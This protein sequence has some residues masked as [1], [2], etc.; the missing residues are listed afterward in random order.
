MAA[1]QSG[2]NK[3]WPLESAQ[4][5]LVPGSAPVQ[6][7]NGH[8]KFCRCPLPMVQSAICLSLL[9]L[10]LYPVV[11]SVSCLGSV[12]GAQEC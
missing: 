1:G 3:A 7:C 11:R 8:H 12:C 4:A 2:T 9:Q 5:L 6:Q 10:T